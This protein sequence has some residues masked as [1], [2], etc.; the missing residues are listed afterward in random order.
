MPDDN[1]HNDTVEASVP[2]GCDCE[3]CKLARFEG[4][5]IRYAVIHRYAYNPRRWRLNSVKNDPHDYHLG[6]ELE[7]DSFRIDANGLRVRASISNSQAVSTARPAR[8]WL[9]KADASVSG[10]EFV[11]HPAT[12]AYWHRQSGKLAEMFKMLVH[13]GFR[14]HDNDKAGMHVSISKN[15]FEDGK[16]LFRFLS[17]IHGNA[18]WSLRMSQRTHASAQQW[19]SISY[20]ADPTFRQAEVDRVMPSPEHLATLPYWH[21]ATA[22]NQSSS[23]RYQA[24]NCPSGRQHAGG[25]FE[26]RLPR[27]T[28][29]VDRFLK[30]LEWAVAMVE[31][32]RVFKTVSAMNS[33]VFMWW[34]MNNRAKYPN[35]ANFLVERFDA[36]KLPVPNGPSTG[37]VSPRTGRPVRSYSRRPGSRQPGRPV[38]YSPLRVV[39][40]EPETLVQAT[41]TETTCYALDVSGMYCERVRGHGGQHAAFMRSHNP[42]RWWETHGTLLDYAD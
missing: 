30:N 26:F 10:P 11:S 40:T 23:T 37:R 29:R 41:T 14:S 22:S 1:L 28:L 9:A 5:K 8:L 12:L 7:T 16:H 19:A 17:I 4:S 27:G 36:D 24:V 32:S 2:A 34:V 38:G 39:T 31:Y 25:R 15:A 13:A 42:A 20:L 35:L 6:V 3:T 33:D 21:Q 18:V